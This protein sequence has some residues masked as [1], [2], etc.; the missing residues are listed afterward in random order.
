MIAI[1]AAHTSIN[2]RM[3]CRSTRKASQTTF[4]SFILFHN[5]LAE[6]GDFTLSHT[7]PPRRFKRTDYIIGIH[8]SYAFYTTGDVYTCIDVNGNYTYF[9]VKVRMFFRFL[10]NWYRVQKC[11]T[12]L[13]EPVQAKLRSQPT[14]YRMEYILLV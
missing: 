2:K 6:L 5:S 12:L 11:G 13:H 14:H 7:G 1:D 8:L 3:F 9:L 4:H 10:S